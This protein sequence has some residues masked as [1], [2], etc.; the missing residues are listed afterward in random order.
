MFQQPRPT[1][2][3]LQ[4][5]GIPSSAWLCGPGAT[6]RAPPFS[7]SGSAPLRRQRRVRIPT[8]AAAGTGG[9]QLSQRVTKTQ[10]TAKRKHELQELL[11]AEDLPV[12]GNK[13]KL[14]EVLLAHLR[15]SAGAPAQQPAT[16]A[17]APSFANESGSGCVI[18]TSRPA[19]TA[20]ADSAVATG[21]VP[22]RSAD[23]EA[24]GPA[25]L[26]SSEQRAGS[27]EPLLHSKVQQAF[28]AQ[29]SSG[30]HRGRDAVADP[31]QPPAPAQGIGVPGQGRQ[32][33]KTPAPVQHF[34]QTQPGFQ[35]NKLPTGLAVQWLGT[36][37]GAPTQ[38]RNVSSILLLQVAIL[39]VPARLD[40]AG[41]ICMQTWSGDRLTSTQSLPATC[42]TS[43]CRRLTSDSSHSG[44]L[45]AAASLQFCVRKRHIDEDPWTLPATSDSPDPVRHWSL[46]VEPRCTLKVYRARCCRSA[47][48]SS[49]W[50]RGR[51]LPVS[52]P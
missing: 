21:R 47:G 17:A 51:G 18:N 25:P 31:S 44:L 13:P 5:A 4:R 6:S 3:R 19:S 15:A 43:Q 26:A 33:T 40:H 2:W 49:W 10:L 37:S 12:D 16:Q 46:E 42:T 20:A 30:S 45:S 27:A 48:V 22:S 14:I 52:C 23:A 39:V 34:R 28:A 9:S 50:T 11:A 1:C 29:Q 35:P 32:H 36:S 24:P 8:A 41:C 7:Q 38:H